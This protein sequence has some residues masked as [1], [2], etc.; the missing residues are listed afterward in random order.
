MTDRTIVDSKTLLGLLLAV[1]DQNDTVLAPV[2]AVFSYAF[3]GWNAKPLTAYAL[4]RPVS[5]IL[6]ILSR[7]S[8]VV[9]QP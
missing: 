7:P 8:D 2:T 1:H 6:W 5:T 4:G 3:I 9:D